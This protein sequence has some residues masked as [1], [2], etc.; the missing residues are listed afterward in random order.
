[1]GINE[2]IYISMCV[3]IYINISICSPAPLCI[4]A[5]PCLHV[6]ADS[7]WDMR[8]QTR[9][10]FFSFGRLRVSRLSALGGTLLIVPL[11]P[12]VPYYR[13][14]RDFKGP[15]IYPHDAKRGLPKEVLWR[16]PSVLRDQK[17]MAGFEPWIVC[18]NT[19]KYVVSCI[20]LDI[21]VILSADT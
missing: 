15:L 17:Q 9:L 18:K 20:R 10:Q 1:M 13:D 12:S 11:N 7:C 8:R 6:L 21:L 2:S 4:T 16:R 14:I 19:A 3:Y 5:S